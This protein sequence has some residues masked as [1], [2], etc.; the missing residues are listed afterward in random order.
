[1]SG[2]FRVCKNILV[3]HAFSASLS[4]NLTNHALVGSAEL[5]VVRDVLTGIGVKLFSL[6]SEFRFRFHLRS[7]ACGDVCL[8]GVVVSEELI[9]LGARHV[10][11]EVTARVVVDGVSVALPRDSDL[12]ATVRVSDRAVLP[13]VDH[14]WHRTSGFC[15]YSLNR[16]HRSASVGILLNAAVLNEAGDFLVEGV[17]IECCPVFDAESLRNSADFRG[18][19]GLDKPVEV[20]LRSEPLAHERCLL[21]ARGVHNKVSRGV[22]DGEGSENAVVLEC[23]REGGG[24]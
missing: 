12:S 10:L 6:P 9:D 4:D 7:R 15:R 16:L 2:D 18:G 22:R 23:I 1:M 19:R 21:E 14:F 20:Y 3:T 17:H 11:G 5:R 13:Q 24:V 8:L